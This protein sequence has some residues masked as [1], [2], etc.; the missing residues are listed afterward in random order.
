MGTP[1]YGWM[2]LYGLL[3]LVLIGGAA[4]AL[5]VIA[6]RRWPPGEPTASLSA[7]KPDEA[8]A[9]LRRRYASGEINREDYLQAKVELED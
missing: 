9:A 4:G 5:C 2:L 6:R 8:Q 3:G 1:M 7:Q